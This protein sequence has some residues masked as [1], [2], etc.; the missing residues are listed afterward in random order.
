MRKLFS[1]LFLSAAPAVLLAQQAQ[2]A[3]QKPAEK[4]VVETQKAPEEQPAAKPR[5]PYPPAPKPGHPLDPADVAVLTGK[6]KPAQSNPYGAYSYPV[7]VD[8]YGT[9]GYPA[10]GSHFG[11]QIFSTPGGM[12]VPEFPPFAM[13]QFR[14]R[15]FFVG[16]GNFGG[17]PLL[18]FTHGSNR[19][20]VFL[21]PG[22]SFF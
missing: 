14:G 22:M 1:V 19:V 5:S 6:N 3:Q 13:G 15:R 8:P 7:F 4:P 21:G 12:A 16:S 17:L 10:G 11:T 9:Y 20:F 18:F 2:P